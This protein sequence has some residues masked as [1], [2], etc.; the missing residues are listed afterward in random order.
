MLPNLAVTDRQVVVRDNVARV[1]LHPLFIGPDRL[2]NLTRHVFVVMSGNVKPLALTCSSCELEG[3]FQIVLT[4]PAFPLVAV[5]HTQGCVGHGKVGVELN[6]LPQ[7]RNGL[8][9]SQ[10]HMF[11]LPQAERFQRFERRRGGLLE[12]HGKLLNRGKRFTQF[13][14]QA[15]GCPIQ[16]LQH[17][18]LAVGLDLFCGEGVTCL[19]VDGGQSGDPPRSG[20]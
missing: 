12:R 3:S 18:F 20:C 1:G 19:G 17:L 5:T 8:V 9:V 14:P 15:G 16:R 7:I 2:F 13:V 11:G 4:L 6:G 10:L